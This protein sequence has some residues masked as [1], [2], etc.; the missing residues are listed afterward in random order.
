MFFQRTPF[1]F[2]ATVL[3]C[4]TIFCSSLFHSLFACFIGK[5]LCEETQIDTARKGT[6]KWP[7]T[8]V[9]KR[10]SVRCPYAYTEPVFVALDCILVDADNSSSEAQWHPPFVDTDICPD[11]PFSRHVHRLYDQLVMISVAVV[12]FNPR[13]VLWGKNPPRFLRE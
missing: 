10:R 3:L 11:P 6:I 7:D 9:G 2:Y 4:L 5:D 1:I 8:V 12:V 13:S